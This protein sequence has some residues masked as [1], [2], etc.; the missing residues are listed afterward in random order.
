MSKEQ[1]RDILDISLRTERVSLL[2]K[3]RQRR[4]LTKDSAQNPLA[5][6]STE[7]NHSFQLF[8]LI[9]EQRA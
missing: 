5:P 9:D 7:K 1:Q 6:T 3:P 2:G 4:Q 8:A